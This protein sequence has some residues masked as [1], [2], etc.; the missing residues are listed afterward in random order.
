M[1]GV[2]AW[3]Y[4]LRLTVRHARRASAF[5]LGAVILLAIGM[6]GATVMLTLIRGIV[7]RPLPVP[8]QDRLVVSWLIPTTGVATHLPYYAGDAEEIDRSSQSFTHVAGVGY[9]G[10][11]EQTWVDGSRAFSARTVAVMGG[12]FDVARV[13]PRLGRGLN[14]EDDHAGAERQVVL[15][16]RLWRRAF[17]GSPDVIG[18]VVSLKRQSFTVV[19]VMP[20][21]FEYPAG[22]ELYA[23]RHALAQVERNEAFRTGL[24]RDIE[25]V[26]RLREGVTVEHARQELAA[27][28]ERLAMARSG[29]RAQGFRP[30][31]RSFKSVVIGDVASALTILLA[32]VGGLL[33][34]AIANVTNLFLLRAE[35]RRREF[36]VRTALGASPGRLVGLLLIEA[37]VVAAAASLVG[38]VMARWALPLIVRAVPQGLPRPESIYID[39]TVATAVAAIATAAAAFAGVVPGIMAARSDLADGLRASGRGVAGSASARGR[40]LLVAGQVALAVTVIA[41]AVLLGRSLQRLTAADMGLRAD[42]LVLAELELPSLEYADQARRRLFFDALLTRLRVHPAIEAVSPINTL[43]FAGA[44]G[45]DV[46]QFTGEGQSDADV[47][48]NP[49]LN[50]EVVTPDYFETLGVPIIR[51]RGFTDADRA[52]GLPVAVVSEAVA[53]VVW[54]DE[55]PVGRRLKF[56]R[57]ESSGPWLTVV[58]VAA[59]TRYRELATPRPTLYLP[60]DQFMFAFGRLAIRSAAEPS[61]VAAAVREAVA[62]TDGAVLVPRVAPYAHHLRGP[63]AWPRFHAL[64]FSVFAVT[65]LALTAVGLYAVMSASVRQRGREIAVRLAL[66]A[67]GSNARR[68]VLQEALVLAIGGVSLGLLLA[69]VATRALRGLLYETSALDPA[70]LLA[71]SLLLVG[72]ALAASWFPARRAARVDPMVVLRAE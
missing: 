45:W 71:A 17:G 47:I 16:H 34:I 28:T 22:A 26:A 24:V 14:R 7:L 69:C 59:T 18:H 32:A 66:G 15:S 5:Y 49:P 42:H 46:P 64:L 57:P 48:A 65:S 27:L 13:R 40:R 60:A 35:H 68:L 21:D 52:K 10:A 70:S 25:I 72:G 58:G 51:G 67:T 44:A 30:M 3:F 29:G 39:A 11:V 23:T 4:D 1:H 50:F 6:A 31:V 53:A 38:V 33:A 56:G 61:V 12:F 2:R 20:P 37:S 19:G 8:D 41:S 9:N 62:A 36:A 63:L 54:P 55:D 43:P